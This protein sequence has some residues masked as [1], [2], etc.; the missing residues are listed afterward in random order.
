MICALQAFL[1]RQIVRL[2]GDPG[3]NPAPGPFVL[4]N[5]DF[6]GAHSPCI[7]F[8]R[9]FR[10]GLGELRKGDC[11]RFDPL[12]SRF[13]GPGTCATRASGSKSAISSAIWF[14]AVDSGCRLRCCKR[15]PSE[16]FDPPKARFWTPSRYFEL[17]MQPPLYTHLREQKLKFL[18]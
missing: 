15:V 16:H 6:E 14:A 18:F 8:A 7:S 4:Q 13:S 1:P 11:E 10:L 17:V 12:K 5:G 2:A 3:S 9:P